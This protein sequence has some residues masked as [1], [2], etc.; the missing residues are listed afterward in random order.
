MDLLF[1]HCGDLGVEIEWHDLGQTRRGDYCD[2]LR[3]IR[4]NTRLT[5]A[6]ATACLAHETAHAILH[7]RVSSPRIERRADEYG[8]SLIIESHD[9]AA[10]EREVGSHAGALAIALGVTPRLIF[11]WRRWY[12]KSHD[13]M[14]L[15]A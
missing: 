14:K 15:V 13:Q 12:S 7:D 5:A 6:Q 8:A 11:A 3:L 2:D 1:A 10:A 9:Y 4:L